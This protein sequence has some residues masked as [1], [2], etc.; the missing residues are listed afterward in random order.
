MK[1]TTH[2]SNSAN[3]RIQETVPAE[4]LLVCTV[5]FEVGFTVADAE[6]QNSD[7]QLTQALT[8][9]YVS[10]STVTIRMQYMAYLA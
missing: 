7:K 1:L 10:L 3:I 6:S 2:L 9:Q 5:L 4:I 8:P